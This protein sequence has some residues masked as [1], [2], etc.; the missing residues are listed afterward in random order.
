MLSVI[1]PAY[2]EEEMI[3]ITAKRVSE[4]LKKA[5]IPYEILF[6]NDG[7]KDATWDKIKAAAEEMESIRGISFSKN[8][9]KEAAMMA[10][11]AYARGEA[12]VIIDCD[13]QHPPEKLIEMY[14]LWQ[15]GYKVVEGVKLSRGKESVFHKL[16]AEMFYSIISKATGIDMRNASDFKLMDREV[17]E[18]I[19]KMP[20]RQFF[21]RAISSWVGFKSAAVEFEVQE[22][23]LGISKWSLKS[24]TKYAL[25]NIT[26]FSSAPLQLVTVSG[27]VFLVFALVLGVQTLIKF[28]T[29]DALEG[30]TT[31]IMLQLISSS[32]LMLAVGIIGYYIAKIYDEVKGRPRYI[33]EEQSGEITEKN[34][35]E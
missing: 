2:C 19:L 22:R 24:L 23:Q 20:E 29:G 27:I 4:I 16:A 13:L 1:I 7:S 12:C 21:F 8:F 18:T 34:A 9:G 32:I 33:V 25:T 3:S 31:V 14:Q 11:L 30:F 17:V 26:S 10:G 15:E 6:V 5:E 28:I 35:G